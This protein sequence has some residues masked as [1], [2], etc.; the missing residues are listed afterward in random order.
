MPC[1]RASVTPLV[2]RFRELLTSLPAMDGNGLR[3]RDNKR[4]PFRPGFRP[5][6]V[7]RPSQNLIRSISSSVILSPVRSYSLVVCEDLCA[8]MARASSRLPP[9]ER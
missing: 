1:L 2:D 9:L 3:P 8:A 7:D 6:R 4:S 5:Y